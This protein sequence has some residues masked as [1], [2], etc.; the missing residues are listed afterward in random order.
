MEDKIFIFSIDKWVLPMGA[1]AEGQ[2]RRM[3]SVIVEFFFDVS[4]NYVFREK[5]LPVWHF[6]ANTLQINEL[7]RYVS[8]KKGG[9][10]D[11]N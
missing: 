11:K 9:K 2:V 8:F 5:A 7:G 6:M 4:V 3:L 1:W 10:D